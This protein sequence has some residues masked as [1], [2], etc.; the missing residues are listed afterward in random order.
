MGKNEDFFNNNY[1]SND[2]LRDNGTT[3]KSNGYNDFST[4]QS[5]L[6]ETA[7]HLFSKEFEMPISNKWTLPEP[8]SMLVDSKWEVQYS[9][10]TVP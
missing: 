9:C 8:E 4:K 3:K 2:Y 6:D 10:I 1:N 5:K 7:S